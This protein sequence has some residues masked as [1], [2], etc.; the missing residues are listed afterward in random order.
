[1]PDEYRNSNIFV[2]EHT[3]MGDYFD[4]H[5]RKGKNLKNSGSF[6]ERNS[7]TA[8]SKRIDRQTD[9][10]KSVLAR[11]KAAWPEYRT[12][13]IRTIAR[14]LVHNDKLSKEERKEKTLQMRALIKRDYMVSPGKWFLNYELLDT[15]FKQENDE[16]YRAL[17][18]HVAQNIL[19]EVAEAFL[20]FFSANRRYKE[21]PSAF[22]GRPQIPGYLDKDAR[23]TITY[24]AGD[25][26]VIEEDG[27][28][29]L[30]F[31]RPRIEG[32]AFKPLLEISP[33]FLQVGEKLGEVK[34]KPLRHGFNVSITHK[35]EVPDTVEDNGRYFG[36]DLG[37][38]N[39]VTITS[40]V[41]GV[42]PLIV[43]GR[44]LKSV[45]QYFNKIIADMKS[46]LPQGTYTSEAIHRALSKREYQIKSMINASAHVVANYAH[47][48][49]ISRVIIGKNNRWKDDFK[50]YKHVKQ[51]F[52]FVPFNDL[53]A[54]IKYACAEYGI[55]VIVVEESYTSQ[56]SL[57]DG[58]DIPVWD[59]EHHPEYSFS[60]K[61]VERGLYRSAKGLLLNADV[62]GGGNILRKWRANAF[63]KVSD[64]KFLMNPFKVRLLKSGEFVLPSGG[65]VS[66][67]G[68]I[69]ALSGLSGGVVAGS[70]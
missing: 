64:Y 56:A 12:I 54:S 19:E 24:S 13:A 43:G 17:Y 11:L 20:S 23:A 31:P 49:F 18:S 48:N 2:P 21:D 22:T 27:K 39:L 60:G 61:R 53:I 4:H 28:R 32:Q 45:N 41:E 8:T 44:E 16:N 46:Q 50:A 9:N 63:D 7:M 36:L 47:V 29:C 65:I 25:V 42:R 66:S 26:K 59:G 69:P 38:E 5:T 15:L 68:M 37:L 57:V 33:D 35:V 3:T 30:F 51:S 62:N 1:M 67:R 14:E 58:D 40:N 55:E 6:V 10:E 52:M 70:V 34:V